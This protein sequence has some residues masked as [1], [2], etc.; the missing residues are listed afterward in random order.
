MI[1]YGAIANSYAPVADRHTGERRKV[2]NQGDLGTVREVVKKK[3][4]FFRK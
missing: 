3:S 4:T 2:V 1:K